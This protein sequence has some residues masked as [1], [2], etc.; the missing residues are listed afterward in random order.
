ME[1]RL[2]SSAC[3]A[4]H[5]FLN[6]GREFVEYVV[7]PGP[8]LLHDRVCSAPDCFQRPTGFCAHH[9]W[10]RQRTERVED[11]QAAGIARIRSYFD[12]VRGYNPAQQA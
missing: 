10:L 1:Q 6:T 7:H 8:E 11:D 9:Q 12:D 2:E 5:P 3:A 4:D